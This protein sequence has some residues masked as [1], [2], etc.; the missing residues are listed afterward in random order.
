MTTK[1]SEIAPVTRPTEAVARWSP[2]DELN[3]MRHR[4]DDLFAR[5][6][7][8]TP[9]SRMLPEEV[10]T[11]EPAV[12][13]FEAPD[14]FEAFIAV[15]GFT[16][17]MINVS[18]TGDTLTV[19]GERKALA[20]VKEKTPRRNGWVSGGGSFKVDYTM[21]AEIEPNK[22]KATFKDGILHVEMPKSERAL[23]K[24]VKVKVEPV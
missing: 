4:M 22:I 18:A 13:L 8:Y 10:Y 12:D 16:P 11:F 19:E 14:H 24:T 23:S 9:L 6:F 1:G 20:D 5:A 21:N 15:P 17:D 2:L 3:E 7:G